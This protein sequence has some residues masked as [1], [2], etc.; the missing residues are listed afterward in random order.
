[1][2]ATKK[3]KKIKNIEKKPPIEEGSFSLTLSVEE[4]LSLIQILGFSK[5]IFERMS[6]NCERDGDAKLATVYGA[7][8]Q[9]SLMLY[10]R[11]KTV[12]GIGEPTSRE[13]H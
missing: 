9:L 7:R 6:L 10:D 1:M 4:M 12:A 13:V 5:D 8:S 3:T 2:P 11:L